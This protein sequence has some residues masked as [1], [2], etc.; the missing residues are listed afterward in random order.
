[1]LLHG[2]RQPDHPGSRLPDPDP[3]ADSPPALAAQ[4]LCLPA[5]VMKARIWRIGIPWYPVIRSRF[6]GPGYRCGTR[7]SPK[8][9]FIRRM[10]IFTPSD[11]GFE[12][13]VGTTGG[14]PPGHAD[15]TRFDILWPEF[16]AVL[17][18][19]IWPAYGKNRPT[20]FLLIIQHLNLIFSFTFRRLRLNAATADAVAKHENGVN[21]DGCVHYDPRGS[22]LFILGMK[23]MTDGLQMSAGKRI[24]AILSAVSS[25]PGGGLPDRRRCHRHGPILVGHHRDAHRIRHRRPDDPAT[26]RWA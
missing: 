19:D 4:N 7:L 16:S 20:H 2:L 11:T 17:G 26:S 8:S 9:I 12:A 6:T 1:M 10:W 21:D 13:A 14:R 15:G 22:W 25:E 5:A 24:K 3:G 23:M 18:L